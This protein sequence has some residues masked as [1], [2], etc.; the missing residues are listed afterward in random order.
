MDGNGAY[1]I[2]AFV[3]FVWIIVIINV[4]INYR[5]KSATIKRLWRKI[6]PEYWLPRDILTGI[7]FHLIEGG[8]LAFDD[9]RTRL[10][11]HR[12]NPTLTQLAIHSWLAQVHSKSWGT[13]ILYA[14]FGNRP[15]NVSYWKQ[16]VVEI[17]NVGGR[18]GLAL[19]DLVGEELVVWDPVPARRITEVLRIATSYRSVADYKYRYTQDLV[20]NELMK[21]KGFAPSSTLK[22]LREFVEES[23]RL[24]KETH[25]PLPCPLVKA[26]EA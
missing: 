6:Y 21:T 25:A 15:G 20:A 11:A 22:N 19:Y 3:A 18:I 10:N 1:A 8:F 23:D 2:L 26:V 17:K 14:P 13:W 5:D 4:I 12:K 9:M 24:F 7:E 16:N